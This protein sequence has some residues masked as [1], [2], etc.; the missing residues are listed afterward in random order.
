LIDLLGGKLS[1]GVMKRL[2]EK[3][4]GCFPTPKE[5]KMR[6]SCPD[7]SY[8]CKHIAAV[9]YGIGNRLDSQPELLFLLRG[10][11]HLD[12]VSH[13]VSKENLERELD[14][15]TA[16]DLAGQDLG[17]MFGIELDGSA[18]ISKGASKPRSKAKSIAAKRTEV[19][20]RT[21]VAKP[22]PVAS[23]A[24]SAR[25]DKRTAPHKTA[26]TVPVKTASTTRPKSARSKSARSKSAS[27]K[28]T[29]PKPTTTVPPGIKAKPMDAKVRK[30]K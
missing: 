10:V 18:A 9:M 27:L 29:K 5:I 8:C 4:E 21:V 23:P 26:T 2:T 12:L 6:C 19:K 30:S 24:K 22:T 15:S 7:Y 16:S 28:T 25:T 14:A 17:A 1:N 3:H 20:A 13:A 11:D